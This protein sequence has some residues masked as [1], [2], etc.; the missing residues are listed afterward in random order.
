MKHSL[1]LLSATLLTLLIAFSPVE[2]DAQS[3]NQDTDGDGLTDVQ[4]DANR[5]G[6]LDAGETNPYDA[7]GDNG[8]ESDGSEVAAR[9]NP[10]D[11]TD[12]MTA[13]SDGD[14]LVNGLELLKKTDPKNADTDGD[15]LIDRDDPFPLDS[16]FQQDNNS[17]GLPDEWEAKTNLDVSDVAPTPSDDPDGDSLTNAEEFARGTDPLNVDT[18]RD[19]VDD[20]TEID[21]G[22]DPAENA[23]FWYD[24][25]TSTFDDMSDHWSVSVVQK[26]RGVSILPDASPLIRGY[27]EGGKSLFK[28]DQPVT[29]FEFLK[30][31]LLSTCTKLRSRSDS[32]TVTFSD[33]RKDFRLGENAEV[34]LR[35]QVIYT[36][37]HYGIVA[38]YED[39]TFRPDAPVNRA[40][41][42]KI[43]SL[44]S[45]LSPANTD[46]APTF[47]DVSSTDWFESYVRSAAAREIVSGYGDGTFGPGNSITRAE[48]A[49]IVLN[50]MLQNP[51]VNG[52]DLIEE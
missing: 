26:L 43:L 50:T 22:N 27:T 20:K 39:G 9:R 14:G 2:I 41:A 42:L 10:D 52:Y 4:E 44:G 32:E 13:D 34:A 40:E 48:A 21:A 23:C 46:T 51:L 15:G 36:A 33:V 49:K 29:R 37:A 6:I 18:D 1:R 38:G 25:A 16:K 35:R 47:L 19:G 31:V 7:D 17:N 12:D 28:P 8:G 30:M 5:N 11:P 24:K 45:Q 3:A